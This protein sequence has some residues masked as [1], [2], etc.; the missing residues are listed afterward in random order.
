MPRQSKHKKTKPAARVAGRRKP[1]WALALLA[2]GAL[3]ALAV[4]AVPVTR[5]G[6]RGE[7]RY[8]PAEFAA[9][10]ELDGRAVR[11]Y[12]LDKPALARKIHAALP[13]AHVTA[14]NRGFP[15]L[16]LAVE[17]LVPVFAQEQGGLWWLLS[18]GGKL[19]ESAAQPTE[20]LLLL[21]GAR[22]QSPRAGYSA[23]WEGAFTAPGD[24]SLLRAALLESPLWSEITGLRVCAAALP[25]VL[26]QDRIRLR[27]GAVFSQDGGRDTLRQKLRTAEDTI[28]ELDAQ[29]PDFHGIVDVYAP[30]KA[31]STPQWAAPEEIP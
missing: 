15:A 16:R 22:L 6:I 2:L 8:S 25:E 30:G 4:L 10:L 3:L 20:G 1:K 17:E 27:L 11:L 28:R 13:Y 31:Y 14:V 12:N 9:A 26:Y 29:N 21:T 18:D 5:C 24:L 19:L 23:R 7:T